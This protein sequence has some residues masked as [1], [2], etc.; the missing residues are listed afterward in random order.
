MRYLAVAA[1]MMSVL[2]TACSD[3]KNIPITKENGREILQKAMKQLS[4]SDQALLKAALNRPLGSANGE[5]PTGLTVAHLIEKEKLLEP[6]EKL[7]ETRRAQLRKIVS[8]SL[9]GVA[10]IHEGYEDGELVGLAYKNES[11]RNVRAFEGSVEYCDV[12]GNHLGPS[13]LE[14]L[15]PMTPGQSGKVGDRPGGLT[16]IM[17]KEKKVDDLRIVWNPSK[18]VFEDGSVMEVPDF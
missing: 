15:Q 3:V 10:A 7:Q 17:L 5:I 9:L 14:V 8:V 13:W 12:L 16:R 11:S 18:I 4:P 1:M 6:Q 2:L